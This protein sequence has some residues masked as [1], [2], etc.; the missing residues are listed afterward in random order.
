MSLRLCLEEYPVRKLVSRYYDCTVMLVRA[1]YVV[2]LTISRCNRQRCMKCAAMA[3][4]GE[5]RGIACGG[6]HTPPTYILCGDEL[7]STS[8]SRTSTV[9]P[10]THYPHVAHV[11]ITS[12][13]T[14]AMNGCARDRRLPAKTLQKTRMHTNKNATSRRD[15]GRSPEPST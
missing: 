15:Q 10:R 13:S 8:R 12:F 9:R 3:R 2:D 14:R 11:I 6:D 5:G 4:L 1:R 7:I